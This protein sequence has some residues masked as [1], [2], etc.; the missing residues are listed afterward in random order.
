MQFVVFSGNRE[1][2]KFSNGM[3]IVWLIIVI[4]LEKEQSNYLTCLHI[5]FSVS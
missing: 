4:P 5:I 3:L 1:S 2:L